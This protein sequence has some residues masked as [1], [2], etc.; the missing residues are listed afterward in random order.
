MVELSAGEGGHQ[1]GLDWI[2][3]DWIACFLGAQS[4][5]F[6]PFGIAVSLLE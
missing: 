2:G 4:L 3:L 1:I 5:D 6:F